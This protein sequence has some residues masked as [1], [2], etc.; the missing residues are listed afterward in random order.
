MIFFRR[1]HEREPQKG[2]EDLIRAS[3]VFDMVGERDAHCCDHC[4]ESLLIFP[5]GISLESL[6]KTRQGGGEGEEGA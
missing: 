2:T 3:K 6:F 1:K 5:E 4:A